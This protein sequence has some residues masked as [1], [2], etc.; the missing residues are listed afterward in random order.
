MGSGARGRKRQGGGEGG[1]V[2]TG[3]AWISALTFVLTISSSSRCHFGFALM[4]SSSSS[5]LPVLR[6]C[7]DISSRHC[8]GIEYLSRSDG[9]TPSHLMSGVVRLIE[10]YDMFFEPF[11]KTDPG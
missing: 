2:S 1:V 3:T 8:C 5:S 6:S 9:R 11:M 7:S 10:S 4:N